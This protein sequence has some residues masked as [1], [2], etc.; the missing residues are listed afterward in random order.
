[1]GLTIEFQILSKERNPE[2]SSYRKDNS[3]LRTII[4]IEQNSK[5]RVF[6]TECLVII[7]DK[8]KIRINKIKKN[9][10]SAKAAINNDEIDKNF[11]NVCEYIDMQVKKRLN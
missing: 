7:A 5:N 4:A 1:M 8:T 6:L 2:N 3:I 9:F 10:I 11:N